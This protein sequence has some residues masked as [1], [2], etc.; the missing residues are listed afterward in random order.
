[1]TV[2]TRSSLVFSVVA[3][4]G[5]GIAEGSLSALEFARSVDPGGCLL[6]HIAVEK[7]INQ[8]Q[9]DSFSPDGNQIAIGWDRGEVARGTYLL[10]LITGKRTVV[11]AL[12]NGATFSPDGKHL[13]NSIYVENGKTDLVLY[14]M[15]SEK[16][17]V[18]AEHEAWEWLP[19]YSPDGESIVFNSYRN[20]NSDVYILEL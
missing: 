5:I 10:D 17:T 14:E 6:E 7:G 13:L 11:P 19:S 3:A 9:Y 1:V 15:A 8:F 4:L 20:G 2:V 12:N 16:T 18:L